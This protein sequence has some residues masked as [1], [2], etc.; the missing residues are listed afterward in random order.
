MEM[1]TST[2]QNGKTS[3]FMIYLTFTPQPNPSNLHPL[4][5]EPPSSFS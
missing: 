2:E 5:P 3:L 4:N 1:K